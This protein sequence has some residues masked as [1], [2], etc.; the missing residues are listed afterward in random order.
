MNNIL[1]SVIIPLYNKENFIVKTVNSVLN[2]TFQD[3][4]IIIVEDCST[5]TSKSIA[6][7]IVSDKIK[8]IDALEKLRA[9]GSTAGGAGMKLAYEIAEKNLIENNFF[10]FKQKHIN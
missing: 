6:Y 8:I 4:E 3:F 10:S 9:G 2:Q 5:D 1:I 7:S